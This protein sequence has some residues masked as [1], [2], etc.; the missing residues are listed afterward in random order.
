MNKIT[1]ITFSNKVNRKSSSTKEDSWFWL[2]LSFF[3]SDIQI[4]QYN[5]VSTFQ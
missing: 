1:K 2:N 5:E 4:Q 3:G